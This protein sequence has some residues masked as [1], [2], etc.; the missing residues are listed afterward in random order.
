MTSKSDL[1]LSCVPNYLQGV[2]HL[3]IVAAFMMAPSLAADTPVGGAGVLAGEVLPEISAGLGIAP[4][5]PDSIHFGKCLDLVELS[6]GTLIMMVGAPDDD[7]RGRLWSQG[8]ASGSVFV[9]RRDGAT[10]EWVP[11][12]PP[13]APDDKPVDFKLYSPTPQP[14]EQFGWSLDL[15]VDEAGTCRAVIGAPGRTH[16]IYRNADGS[17]LANAGAAYVYV[18]NNDGCWVI[19]QR[20]NL[21]M[22]DFDWSNDGASD[23]GAGSGTKV[24]VVP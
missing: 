24:Q 23:S 9:Y 17:R 4:A 20:L 10:S 11:F 6:N 22:V 8:N 12:G 15:D 2:R 5:L 7:D 18:L 21:P 19:E 14:G 1:G 16:E 3:S 13:N